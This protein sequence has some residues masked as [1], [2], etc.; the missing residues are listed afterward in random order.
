MKFASSKKYNLGYMD[1]KHQSGIKKQRAN[2]YHADKHLH[3]QQLL[4][5]ESAGAAA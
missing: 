4:L 3:H 5:F 1:I 2:I